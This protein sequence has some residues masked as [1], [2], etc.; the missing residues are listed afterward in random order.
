MIDG[1]LCARLDCEL[2]TIDDPHLTIESIVPVLG[3][4]RI[5]IDENAIEIRMKVTIGS[6]T[7]LT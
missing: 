3:P 4:G 5:L 7:H 1:Y 2:R 6:E